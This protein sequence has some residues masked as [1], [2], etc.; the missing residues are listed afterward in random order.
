MLVQ[1]QM[2]QVYLFFVR[3]TSII[4]RLGNLKKINKKFG[5]ALN[6][7]ILLEENTMV[8]IKKMNYTFYLFKCLFIFK[9][10]LKE[11]DIFRPSIYKEITLFILSFRA[12]S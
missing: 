6:G 9:D 10:L 4:I 11:E 7:K 2:I 1:W 12:W 5:M 3:V 8:K